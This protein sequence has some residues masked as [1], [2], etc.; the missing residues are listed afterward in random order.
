VANGNT[1][2]E[3]NKQTPGITTDVCFVDQ[4]N[5][6]HYEAKG[7]V[8]TGRYALWSDYTDACRTAQ[9]FRGIGKGG[10]GVVYWPT[11]IYSA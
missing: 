4:T 10:N 8:Q 3:M 5:V 2:L 9:R 7:Y 1:W 11:V 6:A